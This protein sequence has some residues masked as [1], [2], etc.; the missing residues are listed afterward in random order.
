MK[1]ISLSVIY[2]LLGIFLVLILLLFP[3]EVSKDLLRYGVVILILLEVINIS[4]N[5][6]GHYLTWKIEKLNREVE[7][8][9]QKMRE[10]IQKIRK[11][12]D[13]YL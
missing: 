11:E 7:E 2:L 8:S 12:I 5:L 4:V 1:N 13:T 3:D 10:E 6:Y 9:K